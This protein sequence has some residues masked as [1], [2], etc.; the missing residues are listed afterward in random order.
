MNDEVFEYKGNG[1]H[2]PKAVVS[3]V[4]HPSVVD[5]DNEVFCRCRSLRQVVL[6]DGLKRIGQEAFTNGAFQDCDS[7]ELIS[8]PSTV[9]EIG[10][11]A[12]Y[13]CKSLKV[14]VLNEGLQKIGRNSF[15]GCATLESITIPSTVTRIDDYAFYRCS[16]LKKLVL[17]EGLKKIGGRAFYGCILESITIPSSV[18]E[19]G[20]CAFLSCIK[21]KEVVCSEVLPM[22]RPNTFN[23]CPIL[24]RITFPNLSSRL[25]DMIGAGH[26][27]IQDKIQQYM[28]R[29]VIEWRRGGTIQISPVEVMRFSRIRR[30]DGWGIVKEHVRRIVNWIKYY[31]MKEATTIFELALWKAKID[32]QVE[33]DAY[34]RDRKKAKIDQVGDTDRQEDRDSFRVDVPGPVKDAIL[35][36]LR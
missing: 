36:Y 28:N 18:E 7:L 34:A 1:Q 32:Q 9:T 30:G 3:V 25:Y 15:I 26:F 27:D 16:G 4:F 11:R 23:D 24:E 33:E 21:L 14:V 20:D 5:I 8:F 2:V 17:N 31:E 29:G 22:I 19:I 35:Q 12:F 6:N 13:D 10:Y